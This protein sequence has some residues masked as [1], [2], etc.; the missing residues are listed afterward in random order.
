VERA[1][2]KEFLR[3]QIV[4]ISAIGPEELGEPRNLLMCGRINTCRMRHDSFQQTFLAQ[5]VCRKLIVNNRIDCDG[6]LA[7]PVR[8]FLLLRSECGKA[9][10]MQP[11]KSG[12]AD[13]FD[14]RTL[15]SRSSRMLPKTD[16]TAEKK[17]T[18]RQSDRLHKPS[19]TPM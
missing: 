6:S 4:V 11:Q 3:S 5:P 17:Q 19:V 9:R 2:G 15:R 10:G 1:L 13:T 12:V 7:Q 8:E 16:R 18:D 14:N